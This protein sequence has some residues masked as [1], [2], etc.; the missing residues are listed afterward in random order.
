MS[1]PRDTGR[2]SAQPAAA[3]GSR[4]AAAEAAEAAALS[5]RL[6]RMSRADKQ[7]FL[8][9]AVT[10]DNAAHVRA[11]LTHG[12]SPAQRLGGVGVGQATLVLLAAQ[13]DF[14]DVLRALL[15][16]GA[17]HRWTDGNRKSALS[18]AVEAGALGTMRVLLEEA[19]AEVD[20][21]DSRGATPLA[22]AAKTRRA[23]AC[24]L[25][26]RHGADVHA[27]NNYT[28]TPAHEAARAGAADVLNLLLDAGARVDD[29]NKHGETPLMLAASAGALAAVHALLSR[30]ADAAQRQEEKGNTA[31]MYACSGG[32]HADV[33]A[34]LLPH[35][36]LDVRNCT[37][38]AAVH[39]AALCSAPRCFK[40][41]L[42]A[43]PDAVRVRTAR[44]RV[45]H[46]VTNL[47]MPY[48]QTVAHLTADKGQHGMLKRALAAGAARAST[49]SVGTT[50]L[51]YACIGRHL[52]CITLLLGASGDDEAPKMTA[53]EVNARHAAARRGGARLPRVVR[54]AARG[55]RG[56]RRAQRKRPLAAARGAHHAPGRRAAAGAAGRRG[57]GWP[58]CCR[59]HTADAADLVLRR[60]R[61]ARGAGARRP[62]ARVRPLPGG[63]LLHGGVPAVRVADAQ[64]GLQAHRRREAARE[65]AEP[66]LRQRL[67]ALTA[68]APRTSACASCNGSF[69]GVMSWWLLASVCAARRLR[70][71][72][73]LVS[74]MDTARTLAP[75]LLQ[76]KVWRI[77]RRL[78]QP[79]PACVA[80]WKLSHEDWRADGLS[81]RHAVRERRRPCGTESGQGCKKL[82]RGRG[83]TRAPPVRGLAAGWDRSRARGER[84]QAR[85]SVRR[86]RV[87][88]GGAACA[89][90]RSRVGARTPLAACSDARF[91]R[92]ARHL[93]VR[94]ARCVPP[95][96]TVA[97][98]GRA[99]TRAH[100]I[101]SLVSALTHARPAYAA[102]ASTNALAARHRPRRR[103][104]A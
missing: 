27:R 102:S 94:G 56:R 39:V 55:A 40:L 68:G 93:R 92:H 3:A 46:P 60:V 20:A 52:P 37:G 43:T 76:H 97:A 65:P 74:E 100:A 104:R 15:A 80:S 29:V 59:A 61:R 9:A 23:A 62:A 41:L 67:A 88:G 32:D 21:R 10:S 31:L 49:D 96:L 81:R 73:F 45:V 98:A 69:V 89:A 44:T 7:R 99:A 22:D 101:C 51:H 30:G 26:L 4:A 16:G 54:R 70:C 13:N 11:A 64:A 58:S 71:L 48:D 53:A 103:R 95:R 85:T 5:S 17:S 91:V 28:N 83:R 18:Y 38:G 86:C 1:A 79:K 47:V 42:A 63:A 8:M 75:T 57:D 87:R 72:A 66:A 34:A 2:A 35:S 36:D 25:L 82:T 12:A 19:G 14:A 24:A 84:T 78:Q 50:P 6:R 33:A 77:V 90:A